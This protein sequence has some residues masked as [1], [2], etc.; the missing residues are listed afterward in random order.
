[1]RDNR[2]LKTIRRENMGHEYGK[3]HILQTLSEQTADI[4]TVNNT[5]TSSA[6]TTG[7]G[8]TSALV[9]GSGVETNTAP[10]TCSS[11]QAPRFFEPLQQVEA[12]ATNSKRK[13]K[14]RL[15]IIALR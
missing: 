12:K 13:E 8:E 4:A 15:N 11:L 3:T 6:L 5:R 10:A 14:K 2:E 1:L 7:P 9:R